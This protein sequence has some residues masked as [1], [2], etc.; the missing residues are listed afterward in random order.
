[1]CRQPEQEAWLDSPGEGLVRQVLVEW[2]AWVPPL[3]E[4]TVL[5]QSAVLVQPLE[6]EVLPQ[7]LE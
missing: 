3:L 6:P 4:Q 2:E 1:M 7:V 5:R